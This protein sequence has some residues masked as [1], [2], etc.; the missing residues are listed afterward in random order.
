MK[1]DSTA[2]PPISGDDELRVGPEPFT[3][4]PET[5]AKERKSLLPRLRNV[6]R[7]AW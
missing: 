5:D 1:P 7:Y 6:R 3:L 4:I 2:I